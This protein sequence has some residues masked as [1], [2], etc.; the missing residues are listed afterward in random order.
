MVVSRWYYY[1]SGLFLLFAMEAMDIFD[2]LMY[3]EWEGKPGDKITQGLNLL[4]IATSLA[5]FARGF[6][7]NRT[8]GLSGVLALVAVGFLF[9]SMLWSIDPESTMRRAFLYLF[10]V[11]GAIGVA[12]NVSGDEFMDLLAATCFIAAIASLVLLVVS[13]G[14]ARMP[15]SFSGGDMMPNARELRGIFSHKNLLGQVMAAGALASLHG[16]RAGGRRRFRNLIMFVTFVGVGLASESATSMFAIAA[17]CACSGIMAVMR[18]GPAGRLIGAILI[19]ILAPIAA[20]AIVD[21]DSL[22][23]MIGKDPT[24][25]G[26]TDLWVYVLGDI[27]EKPMFGWGF[28]AFWPDSPAAIEIS[29]ALKWS[30]PQAHNGLLEILLEVG[31]VGLAIFILIWARNFVLAVRC[32]YTSQKNLAI[33]ALLCCGGIILIDI[34]ETVLTEPFQILTSVFFILGFE[35]ERAVRTAR[36]RPARSAE[37]V[38]SHSIPARA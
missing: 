14:A 29:N 24:L 1:A 35:C 31:F 34:S 37:T 38:I 15:D 7:K 17:Y 4:M 23:T 12:N 20:W 30:V 21:M 5:L 22:L 28:S 33:S 3:G 10:I 25:T 2:S 11:L 13:P 27:A 9:L 36:R 6:R 18:R 8:I 32:L 16:I 26:R 19:V